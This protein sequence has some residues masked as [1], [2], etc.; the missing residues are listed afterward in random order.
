MDANDVLAVLREPERLH[1]RADVLGAD[2]PVPRR[3]GVYGWYFSGLDGVVPLEGCRE[4]AGRYL[5]YVGI[6]PSRAG[7]G[8]TLRSRIRQHLTNNASGSTLRRTLGSLLADRVGI[9]MRRVGT[10]T[11]FAEGEAVLS[12]W[13]AEHARV[14]WVVT[15]E[16]WTMEP[17]VIAELNLPLNLQHNRDHPFAD[18]LVRRRADQKAQA[19]RLPVIN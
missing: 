14:C 1:G 8:A 13:M 7:S 10:R 11:H 4:V 17:A 3:A 15:E 12:E 6:A 2:D 16:P 5:L 18:E 19:K 9:Q